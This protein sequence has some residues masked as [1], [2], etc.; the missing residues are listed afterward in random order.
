MSTSQVNL[1]L[2]LQNLN[3]IANFIFNITESVMPRQSNPKVEK[4]KA[5]KWRNFGEKPCFSKKK[6]SEKLRNTNLSY[7]YT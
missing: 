4:S 7:F 6:N 5:I 3:R 2:D 1:L